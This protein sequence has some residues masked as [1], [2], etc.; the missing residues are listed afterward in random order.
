MSAAW[1][2]LEKDSTGPTREG[3]EKPVEHQ[4]SIKTESER[5]IDTL[6][7]PSAAS[8]SREASSMGLV[9]VI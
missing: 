1:P 4:W 8:D 5:Y 2:E 3:K 6:G 7:G 9:P